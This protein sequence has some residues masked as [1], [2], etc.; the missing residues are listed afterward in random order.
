MITLREIRTALTGVVDLA[1]GDSIGLVHFDGSERSF[2]RSFWA[3]V[4][5]A[6]AWVLLLALEEQPMSAG[7]LT[8]VAVQI[9]DY[10]LL[11]TAFPLALHE[12]L[13]RR[14][15][16]DRFCLYISIRNWASV[17]ETPAMLFA[18]AFAAAVPFE[19]AQLLPI[20]VMVAVFAFEWFLARVG[21]AVSLGAA[22]AVAGFDFLLSL[23]IQSIADVMLGVGTVVDAGVSQ[24]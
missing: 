11:W 5:V 7:P 24:P 2:W 22:A 19:G 4:I 1:R 20:F 23:I 8:L 14:A 17:I 3:A 21:L 12:I 18:A 15:R 10:V 16:T 9:I 6:P 13:A